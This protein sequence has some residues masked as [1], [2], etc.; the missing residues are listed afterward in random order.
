MTERARRAL[1]LFAF[2]LAW[3]L[4]PRRASAVELEI[5]IDV[6]NED[7]LYELYA[8]DQIGETTYLAMLDVMRKG[9][10]LETATREDLYALP[11]L[12]YADA[13]RIIQYRKEAGTIR[14]PA[15]LVAAG[16]LSKR[17]LLAL[18]PFLVVGQDVNR[19]PV[20]G[21]ARFQSVWTVRDKR[22]PAMMLQAR[23]NA[24]RYLSAGFTGRLTRDR[25]GPVAWD[26]NRQALSADGPKAR[27]DLPKVFIQWDTP[28]YGVIAGSYRIGF[29]QKLTFDN[30][31]RYTP[32]GFSLDDA[33]Y[34]RV[35]P[36]APCRLSPGERLTVDCDN[37]DLQAA[38]DHKI[39]YGLFGVA[40]GAKHISLPVGWLQA[41]GFFS[42]QPRN[43]YQYYIYNKDTCADP[44]VD[45]DPGCSAPDLYARRDPV[46]TP[47]NEQKYQTLPNLFDLIVGG[48]NFSY[49]FD[50]RTHVGVTGYGAAPRWRV[51]GADLDFRPYTALPYGGAFGAVGVDASWGYKWA[52]VF[53][54]FSRSMDS[55][56]GAGNGGYA[57][58]VRH[59]ATFDNHEVEVSA[60]FYDRAFNNPFARPIAAQDQNDGLRAS[61]EA[62]G[63]VRY[64]A[65]LWKRLDL[66]TLLDMWTDVVDPI[67]QIRGQVRGDV[68]ATK[69]FRPGLQLVAQDRNVGSN[70]RGDCFYGYGQVDSVD[71]NDD[72]LPSDPSD[73]DTDLSGLPQACYGERYAVMARMRFQPVK[74]VWFAL[75]YQHEFIDD[76]NYTDS[77]RQDATAIGT[78][79][80]RP[81]EPLSISMRI[82]YKS[83]DIEADDRL[84]EIL[85]GYLEVS[86]RIRRWLTPRIRYDVYGWLDSRDSTAARYPN[87]VHWLWFE[88][89][90][91]F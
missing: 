78:L 86:Y 58:I 59:T 15:A 77:F 2:A 74:Q 13:D 46:L 75:Q 22:P 70:G 80:T 39:R 37:P 38:P 90:S 89:E 66:R 82:R 48:G 36:S 4:T 24:L 14:D 79:T 12:T 43:F 27:V 45:D 35:R 26:P 42:Y 32:N 65:F 61:N 87:P 6:A 73:P 29:G 31:G 16:V 23:I 8:T 64:N 76:Q 69:W 40:A 7:D 17:K 44:T 34:Y 85:W 20:N 18:A 91:R 47:S 33:M 63:R 55:Q 11:N 1:V 68:D 88:L 67:P 51:P 84:E 62:G 53:A 54:E 28:E 49:F 52:D 41:Y 10:D 60:R 71:E 57:G 3:L 5:F 25:I 72:P 56:P 9:T 81:I 19:R 21:Q 83:D 50:R 30:T